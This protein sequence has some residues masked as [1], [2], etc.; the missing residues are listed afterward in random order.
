[1]N[2]KDFIAAIAV[3]QPDS[4]TG[5]TAA[6]STPTVVGGGGIALTFGAEAPTGGTSGAELWFNTDEGKLF[7]NYDGIYIEP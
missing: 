5:A 1:M 7:I 3:R 4:Q 2:Y 6:V